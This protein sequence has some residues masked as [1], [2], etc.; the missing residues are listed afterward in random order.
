MSPSACFGINAH[1][2]ER[3]ARNSRVLLAVGWTNSG[4]SFAQELRASVNGPP[5]VVGDAWRQ[6]SFSEFFGEN[7]TWQLVRVVNSSATFSL[8]W[9][10]TNETEVKT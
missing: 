8:M 1:T 9:W 6:Y 7:N 2:I 10:C 4:Q 5:V 3:S